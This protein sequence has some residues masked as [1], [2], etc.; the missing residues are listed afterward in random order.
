M[1]RPQAAPFAANEVSAAISRG[2]RKESTINGVTSK[3]VENLE[4]QCSFQFNCFGVA[5]MA[6]VVRFDEHGGPEALRIED[7]DVRAP[8]RGE[9]QIRVKALGLNRAEALLRS[10]TYIETPPLPSGLGLEAA[11]IVETVGEGTENFARGEAVSIVPPLSMVRWP[12][13]AIG[14]LSR[15]ACSETSAVARL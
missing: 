5:P 15:R 8:D 1:R 12:P 4:F 3:A 2:S 10:G 9:I 11:G 13:M 14:Q 7:V 6:R